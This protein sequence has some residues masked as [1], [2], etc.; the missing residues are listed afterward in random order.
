MSCAA[1]EK[2]FKPFATEKQEL[3][4]GVP[5]VAYAQSRFKMKLINTGAGIAASAPVQAFASLFGGDGADK[6]EFDLPD[7]RF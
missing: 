2:R 4:P 7:Y 1:Y 6:N 5:A 3:P